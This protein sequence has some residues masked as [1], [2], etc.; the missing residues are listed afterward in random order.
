MH[1]ITP[2]IFPFTLSFS[3]LSFQPQSCVS[4]IS[5][6]T[7]QRQRSLANLRPCLHIFYCTSCFFCWSLELSVCC[8]Q[9]RLHFCPA[10]WAWLRPGFVQKN[11]Q[12]QLLSLIISLSLTPHVRL[13][14]VGTLVCSFQTIG[15][16]Q[17][18]QTPYHYKHSQIRQP[19]WLN[20]YSQ[21]YCR[22]HFGQTPTYLWPFLHYI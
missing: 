4:I 12:P 13:G 19:T 20:L 2:F 11:Q 1:L 3:V 22:Q 9:S 8:Q 17:P 14:G 5:N 7:R 15:N 10:S 18:T 16:T 6:S 21:L